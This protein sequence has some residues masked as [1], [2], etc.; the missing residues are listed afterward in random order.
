MVSKPRNFPAGGLE[1]R[2]VCCKELSRLNVKEEIKSF[3][4]TLLSVFVFLMNFFGK[5]IYMLWSKIFID[6]KFLKPA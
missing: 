3:N 4:V 2:T 6:L 5:F 1:S